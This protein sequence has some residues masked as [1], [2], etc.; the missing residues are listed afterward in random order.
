MRSLSLKIREEDSVRLDVSY[1]KR[2]KDH[3]KLSRKTLV[4]RP[5]EPRRLKELEIL[6]RQKDTIMVKQLIILLHA[7]E[8]FA[9]VPA[10][11]VW[12]DVRLDKR[13]KGHHKLKIERYGKTK[14]QKK[15]VDKAITAKGGID[16]NADKVDNAFAVRN[17]G[18]GIQFH[19]DPAMLK[20]LE[21]AQGFMPVIINIQPMTNLR[22]FLAGGK[23]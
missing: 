5:L 9:D 19:I 15:V 23:Y 14:P 1:D 8:G 21:N 17:S 16:F 4:K 6:A 3:P 22:E 11:S 13:F 7:E 18:G 10:S 12:N 20:Q 2:F